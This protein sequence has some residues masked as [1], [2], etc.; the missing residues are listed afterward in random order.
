LDKHLKIT[1]F[2]TLATFQRGHR[3]TAI[4]QNLLYQTVTWLG[5]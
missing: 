3:V 4:S 5:K 2:G 1:R